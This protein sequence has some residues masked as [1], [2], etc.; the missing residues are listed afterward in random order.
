MI[1][2]AVARYPTAL[3]APV[4]PAAARLTRWPLRLAFRVPELPELEVI[5]SRLR[6]ELA[7]RLITG[8]TL[9]HPALLR[10]VEPGLDTLHGRHVKGIDRHGKLL[11]INTDG[12]TRLCTHLMLNGRLGVMPTRQ[13]MTRHHLLALHFDD[14]TDL[15][16]SESGSR[17]RVAAFV[18]TEPKQ[19][20]W[21][22]RA[23]LDPLGPGFTLKHFRAALD[24]RNRTAKRFLTDQHA[25]AGIGNAYSDEILF[26]ARLSPFQQTRS[27]KPEQSIRLFAAV[28][29]VLHDAILQLKKL[30]RLPERRDR[31]FLKVHNRLGRPCP[32]CGSEVK[33]VSYKESTTYYC[34]G[35]QTGG[36]E[37][38]DRRLS[39]LLK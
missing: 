27:L 37:L 6:L 38:A 7:G 23:G 19:V 25:V 24:R 9:N 14:G 20:P 32:V 28:K 8:T 31:T 35:C 22:A 2:L 26:E 36:K 16:I 39:R 3:R 1:Q 10:T 15:R 33:R 30:D 12:P 4:N 21:I 11:C 13:K 18:V 17:R 29:K 5:R 34:P